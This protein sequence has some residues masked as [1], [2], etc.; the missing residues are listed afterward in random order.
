MGVLDDRGP[1]SRLPLFGPRALL[2]PDALIASPTRC[3]WVSTGSTSS[4][5]SAHRHDH[6]AA[7]VG[8]C[9]RRQIRPSAAF[10]PRRHRSVARPLLHHRALATLAPPFPT[11]VGTASLTAHLVP[12]AGGS[13]HHHLDSTDSCPHPS[14]TGTTDVPDWS[15]SPLARHRSY[16]PNSR[17]GW[18]AGQERRGRTRAP[19]GRG[20]VRGASIPAGCDEP[21][22]RDVAIAS[23]RSPQLERVPVDDA[24]A[25]SSTGG[26]GEACVDMEL[27]GPRELP[28]PGSGGLQGDGRAARRGHIVH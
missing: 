15:G 17:C 6:A 13:R 5:R 1:R 8:W 3:Q 24:G 21:A 28:H 25:G 7:L 23:W 19:P 16:G 27:P 26:E 22:G 11:A 10:A 12:T 2:D 9:N 20:G 14:P 18:L 4:S